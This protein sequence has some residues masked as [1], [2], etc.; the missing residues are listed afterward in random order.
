MSQNEQV[1]AIAKVILAVV[2]KFA[3]EGLWNDHHQATL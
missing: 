1:A 3:K 2:Q